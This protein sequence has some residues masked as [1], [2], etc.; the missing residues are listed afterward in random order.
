[1]AASATLVPAFEM[2]PSAF[3]KRVGSDQQD[4]RFPYVTLVV[5]QAKTV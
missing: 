3:E 4:W 2:T 1:M 5:W